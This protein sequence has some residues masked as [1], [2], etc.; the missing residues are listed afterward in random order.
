M[1][2]LFALF[3]LGA[4]D[5]SE[6]ADDDAGLDAASSLVID[7]PAPPELPA[8]PMIAPC[9]EGWI[10]R[11]LG[12]ATV[13]DP[14]DLELECVAGE[15]RL[16]GRGCVP[17]GA[18]CSGQYP[19]GLPTSGVAY[20]APDG[21]GTGSRL[22]P[23]ASISAAI[24][25][26]PGATVIA[27]AAGEYHES[28]RIVRDVELRGACASDTRIVSPA[29][30]PVVLAS[31]ARVTLRDL[32]L[33]SDNGAG[34]GVEDE[35][36][37]ALRNVRL[38]RA[39]AIGF[40]AT[41]GSTL[42][43]DHVSIG[44]ISQSD[45][46][47]VAISC[48]GRSTCH[49][50][51]S[52]LAHIDGYGIAGEGGHVMV[53]R[54]SFANHL[55][56]P[57]LVVRNGATATVSET[58]VADRSGWAAAI[59]NS[60][61][62]LSRSQATSISASDSALRVERTF[63]ARP[64][65]IGVA[66]HRST[67]RIRDVVVLDPRIE[68][69]YGAGVGGG[70][71]VTESGTVDVARTLL[72]GS[73]TVS[74]YLGGT[75]AMRGEDLSIGEHDGSAD[76]LAIGFSIDDDAMAEITRLR[77]VNVRALALGLGTPGGAAG[78]STTLIDTTIDGVFDSDE[79]AVALSLYGGS[80][81]VDRATIANVES[82]AIVASQASQ[83]T[84]RDL[85]ILDSPMTARRGIDAR[86]G[87][88]IALERV[89]VER[90]LQHGLQVAAEGSLIG[91]H[92]RVLESRPRCDESGCGETPFGIGLGAYFRGHAALTRFEITGSAQCGV[93]LLYGGTVELHEGR[94][95]GH[96]IAV[97]AEHNAID[98]DR[99][100]DRVAYEDN[101]TVLDGVSLPV[102]DVD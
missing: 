53:E 81:T 7:E 93:H 69:A 86:S 42:D 46:G 92:V 23:A 101:G 77:I 55:A 87:S 40:A 30:R 60:Q 2:R 82:V 4:C 72:E 63:I 6:R 80:L 47:T 35:G 28:L 9:P 88:Q 59:Q 11:D 68:P 31:G 75:G 79:P 16:P 43:L 94:I 58:F 33:D 36:E 1:T 32:T 66:V 84:A 37:L 91:S 44:A 13:C 8:P 64:S 65:G 48:F 5:G 20:V 34:A 14:F 78:G 51:D 19:E 73:P 52:E 74:V 38:E 49:V 62:V 22:R 50:V 61:L 90:T 10:E 27:I 98:L 12:F 70:I 57:W 56:D 21:P 85:R 95:A 41:G 17:I 3:W 102:P 25:D 18:P 26:N 97:C 76:A 96:P 54:S 39:E 67:A 15:L 100:S 71:T 89:V 99:V 24:R 29:T 45:F 83:V